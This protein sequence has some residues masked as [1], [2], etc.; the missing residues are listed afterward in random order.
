DREGDIVAEKHVPPDLAESF[1]SVAESMMGLIDQ[2][3][4]MYSA[5][6]KDGQ[7][8]YKYA[9]QGIAV[10][11][12]SRRV[13]IGRLDVLEWISK[14]EVKVLIECSGGTY[15]R[16]LAHD[17]GQRLECG[18]HLSALE[19]TSVGRFKLDDAQPLDE[20]SLDHLIA[21]RDALI[22]PLALASLSEEQVCDIRMG[23]AIEIDTKYEP[24]PIVL[25]DGTKSVVG[26]ARYECNQLHPECVI[27]AESQ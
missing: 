3:P 1:E 19:R 2:I 7:P 10:E 25:L 26:I 8:L 5:V 27:P 15:V 23:R 21:L 9:R 18:A 24:G 16:T 13:H 6:K 11:V 12:R 17:L 22:P 20:V 4:P 14:S